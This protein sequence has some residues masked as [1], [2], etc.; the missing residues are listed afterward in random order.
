MQN[1][2][3]PTLNAQ[4]SS[5][6]ANIPSPEEVSALHFSGWIYL[7]SK[8]LAQATF[9]P[10]PWKR[11]CEV[12]PKPGI[13]PLPGSWLETGVRCVRTESARVWLQSAVVSLSLECFSI[14]LQ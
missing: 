10:K 1:F 9:S 3:V 4:S 5:H 6:R 8:L 13:T 14:A 2:L 11:G 12:V 7:F